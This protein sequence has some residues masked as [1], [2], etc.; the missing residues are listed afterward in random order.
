MKTANSLT[1]K[2]TFMVVA[3]VSLPIF[4]STYFLMRSPESDFIS[5]YSISNQT[6]Y[7]TDMCFS[8]TRAYTHSFLPR[9]FEFWVFPVHN[10]SKH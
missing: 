10:P 3:K 9:T 5:L 6:L 1:Q 4:L 2:T 7:S 8:L